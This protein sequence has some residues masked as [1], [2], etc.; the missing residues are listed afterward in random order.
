MKAIRQSAIITTISSRSDNSLRLSVVTPEL[1]GVEKLAVMDLQNKNIEMFLKPMD[2]APTE[3]IDVKGEIQQKSQSRRLR[4]IMYVYYK[5]LKT[6][7][8]FDEYYKT[9]IEKLINKYKERI[10]L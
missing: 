3:I 8:T 10:N 2:E 9:T 1:S 5:S 6:D 7:Q 4:D